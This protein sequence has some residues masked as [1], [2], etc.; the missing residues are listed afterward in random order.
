MRREIPPRLPMFVRISCSD[1]VDGGW[2]INDS[3]ELSKRLKEIG[4]D[5]IDCSSGGSVAN[6]KIPV[7]PGYQVP[8]AQR[9]RNEAAVAT[10][11]VGLITTARQADAI[12]REGQ[13]DMVLIARQSLRDPYWPIH[14]AIELGHRENL[15][16]PK[17]YGRAFT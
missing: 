9:I 6:A 16:V 4:V 1:W 15:P 14:A 7:A 12:I 13:A 17:Q 11:A 5:L 8:F 2:T 10:A 3:V